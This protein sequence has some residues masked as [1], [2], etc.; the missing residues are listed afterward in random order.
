MG[1]HYVPRKYLRGFSG[2]D[3]DKVWVYDKKERRFF[4]AGIG[5]IAQQKEFYEDDVEVELN[6]TVESPANPVIDKLRR[7]QQIST[8]ERARLAI[9]VAVMLMR[10]PHRR[11][12]AFERYPAVLDDTVRRTMEQI[13][14][15]G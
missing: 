14:H 1:H 2:P 6:A 8:E 3:P 7:R 13:R 15:I 4:E 9:Y 10:V 11:M 5:K 12:K